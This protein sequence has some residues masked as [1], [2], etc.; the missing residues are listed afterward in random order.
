MLDDRSDARARCLEEFEIKENDS[1]DN[2]QVADRREPFYPRWKRDRE[3]GRSVA[4]KGHRIV[5]DNHIEDD[6]ND[7][8]ADLLTRDSRK[9]ERKKAGQPKARKRFQFSK[10]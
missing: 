4:S 1:S 8:D 2:E 9:K 5:D 6:E 10:R 7:R 3:D